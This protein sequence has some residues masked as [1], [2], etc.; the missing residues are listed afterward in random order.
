MTFVDS[1]KTVFA[2]YA[3]FHG[4]ASRSEF[5]WWWLFSMIVSSA[6]VT[7]GNAMGGGQTGQNLAQL[8]SLAVLL[9]SLAVAVRRLRDAG[10]HWANLFWALVPLAGIIVLIIFWIQP[11]KTAAPAGPATPAQA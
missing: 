4:V 7:L 11:S 1:I 6:L 8:W 2:K 3:D 9:P 5:W 10:H